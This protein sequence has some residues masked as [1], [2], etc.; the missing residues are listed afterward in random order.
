MLAEGHAVVAHARVMAFDV[1]VVGGR[2]GPSDGCVNLGPLEFKGKVVGSHWRRS[3]ALSRELRGKVKYTNTSAI[4]RELLLAGR[5][6]TNG[7]PPSGD[8]RRPQRRGRLAGG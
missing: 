6:G 1:D 8:Y 4:S 3:L 2:D 7:P 5:P